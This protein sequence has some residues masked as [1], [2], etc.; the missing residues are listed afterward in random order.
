[1]KLQHPE[2]IIEIANS[3]DG[4]KEKLFQIINQASSFSYP[5]LSIKLQIFSSD[6]ISLRDYE[7][8]EVY[9]NITFDRAFWNDCIEY[10]HK[11]V[12][13]IWVDVFD[14]FGVDIISNNF[15][16]ISG[17]K[18]Q[19][20]VLENQEVIKALSCMNLKN[21]QL[22]VNVSGY[23]LKKISSLLDGFIQMNPKELILQIGY[24]A[25]PTNIEETGLQ[26]IDILK[27]FFN[28]KICLADHLDASSEMAIDMPVYGL[29]IGCDLI[30]KHICLD[31]EKTKYDYYSSLCYKEFQLMFDKIDNFIRSK[32]GPFI[33]E[34]EK[35]Y[36]KGTVQI[37]IS[38]HKLTSGNLISAEDLKFRRTG[39][40]G[41]TYSE[42]INTQEKFMLL[43]NNLTIDSAIKLS[44]FK[45]ASVGVVIAGRLKSS[46]LKRKAILPIMGKP[47]I[48]WCMESCLGFPNIKK[49]ILA[50]STS[51]EDAELENYLINDK[52]SFFYKGERD[53]VIKR[54]I[55][56][57]EKHQIDVVIRVTADCPFVSKEIA[58]IL[59]EEHFRSGADYTAPKKYSVGTNCEIINVAALK[60]VIK[61]LGR[62]D[63]SEY[64]TWYFQNNLD[65]F[66]VNIV[67]LPRDLVRGYRLTLD[68]QEDLDMFEKLLC[69]LGERPVTTQ[70]IFEIL[71]SNPNIS[72]I[73]SHILLKY[74]TDEKLI[75]TLNRVT[76]INL[77]NGN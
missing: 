5:N 39:Q 12:G 70:N 60:K 37:P 46:R 50:T 52:Q 59:L 58:T 45:K 61:H 42:I 66:K 35:K 2:V 19:A 15:E 67:D 51:N 72:N 11:K 47:S 36:L 20:S 16:K 41:L 56:A 76:K 73:N 38:S 13:K 33:S 30:E 75:D 69:V 43:K 25:Y 74:K 53:D 23:S 7:W 24:Q 29:A 62:A 40:E 27:D 57:C 4:N 9:E 32:S 10:S 54:Y 22:M 34:S 63:L 48:Q 18:L 17:I 65:I 8:Y 3:H 77:P 28:Y 21:I 71:D 68:Y 26:K 31:R 14:L 49:V 64:M 44:D 6:T 1:M 55:G